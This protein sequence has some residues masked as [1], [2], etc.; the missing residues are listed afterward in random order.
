MNK[1][2]LPPWP[3]LPVTA[4]LPINRCN[5]P[6]SI[7][8][9][10]SFQR[11]PQPLVIDGILELHSA[12]FARLD[13]L[14]LASERAQYFMDYLAVH[15]RLHQLED[16]GLDH[17][18]RHDRKRANYLRVLR[19]WL[20]DPNGREAA[21]LKAWVESRFGLLPRF[22]KQAIGSAECPAYRQ[23]EQDRAQGLYNTNALEAQ[24]DL[25]YSYCQYELRLD[26]ADKLR[27]YRGMNNLD[28]KFETLAHN[29]HGDPIVLVNSVNSFSRERDRADEFGDTVIAVEIPTAK[30]FYY[31]GLLPGRL[32]GE[33]EYIVIGGL[34]ELTSPTLTAS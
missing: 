26:G 13:Q 21:I 33:D 32:A 34:Y 29:E 7:L 15:F 11:Y 14:A 10:V 12:L 27:L 3:P 9:S 2:D 24:L 16:A 20:F 17:H 1:A 22:H 25:L 30:V 23:Y 6:A 5:L 31:S 8:G 19:G 28:K 4:R 18:S